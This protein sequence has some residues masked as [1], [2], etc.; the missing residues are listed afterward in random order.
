M[1]LQDV[2]IGRNMDDLEP[3]EIK[4]LLVLESLPKPINFTG[5]MDSSV[6]TSRITKSTRTKIGRP[7]PPSHAWSHNAA[8]PCSGLAFAPEYYPTR[9]LSNS[10]TLYYHLKSK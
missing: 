1:V 3:R 2:A 9:I 5:G 7:V 10:A 4:K 8:P 6:A